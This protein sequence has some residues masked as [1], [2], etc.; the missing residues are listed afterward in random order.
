MDVKMWPP[1]PG[2]SSSKITST[3]SPINAFP[4]SGI[5]FIRLHEHLHSWN[6]TVIW[7]ASPKRQKPPF[8]MLCEVAMPS[9]QHRWVVRFSKYIESM[10][11]FEKLLSGAILN[12]WFEKMAK[13]GISRYLTF[14]IWRDFWYQ[15]EQKHKWHK[16]TSPGQSQIMYRLHLNDKMV[17]REIKINT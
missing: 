9:T 11:Q 16:T 4:D 14:A 10:V 5:D 2:W 12:V 8:Q 15:Q 6:V 17:L 1:L 7:N 13:N 3:S